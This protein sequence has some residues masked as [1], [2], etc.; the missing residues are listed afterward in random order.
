MG[1]L[2]NLYP[3][4]GEKLA[5]AC[6]LFWMFSQTCAYK[7]A[8]SCPRKIDQKRERFLAALCGLLVALPGLLAGYVLKSKED[9]VTRSF[10]W[11]SF[12]YSIVFIVGLPPF[13]VHMARRYNSLDNEK[14]HKFVVVGLLKGSPG[15][16]APL[17]Y[18]C[19]AASRCL[20]LADPDTDLRA[21]DG[22]SSSSVL[23]QCGNPILP[24]FCITIFI[25]WTWLIQVLVP[26]IWERE[27]I[28]WSDIA[29][30]TLPSDVSREGTAYGGMCLFALLLFATLH[31][32]GSSAS[33]FVVILMMGFVASTS[34]LLLLVVFDN[35]CC[36]LS[37]ANNGRERRNDSGAGIFGGESEVELDIVS[38]DG[39]ERVDKF[40]LEIG[41]IVAG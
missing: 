4:V 33:T 15:V 35:F 27:P 19:G 14:L 13:A 30:W 22:S 16:L 28:T 1:L 36:T 3:S 18:M 17:L 29:R 38:E 41:A 7:V 2:A 10:G 21:G 6:L 11:G 37:S 12:L 39:E 5:W 20:M 8:F 9:A 26:P 40:D 32:D 25:F 34:L 23:L 31:E 24:T